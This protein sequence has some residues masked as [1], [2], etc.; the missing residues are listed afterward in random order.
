MTTPP[1]PLLRMNGSAATKP[2]RIELRSNGVATADSD[3]MP[4]GIRN[5]P[6]MGAMSRDPHKAGSQFFGG[7]VCFD[8]A[9][10]VDWRTSDAPQE[11]IPDY[12]SFVAWCVRRGVISSPVGARLAANSARQTVPAR[13][14]MQKVRDLRSEIWL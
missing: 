1:M 11:L 12:S 5:N 13:Q 7:R 10:T 2:R 8:F 3:I 4:M 14:T 6:C 9:N